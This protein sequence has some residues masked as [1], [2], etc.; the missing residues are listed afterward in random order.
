MDVVYGLALK[1]RTRIEKWSNFKSK[2]NQIKIIYFTFLT[3]LHELKFKVYSV[4]MK[5]KGIQ[6]ELKH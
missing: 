4:Y 6:K 1:I 5:G 3:K 2:S